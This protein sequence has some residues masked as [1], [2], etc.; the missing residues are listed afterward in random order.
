MARFWI[1]T[2]YGP[3]NADSAQL[4]AIRVSEI[5]A[6]VTLDKASRS[7]SFAHALA[8]RGKKTGMAIAH[9]IMHP[10]DSI[11]GIP[12]GVARYFKR[13]LDM[14]SGRAQSASDRSSRILENK[15]DPY[16]APDGPM[17]AGR[18]GPNERI[19]PPDQPYASADPQ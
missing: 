4:L 15:G 12:M 3:L 16:R 14:W 9:V 10:I 19:D 2:P 7:G 8:A 5:P 13:Q 1:Q 11:T 6:M 17:V 18:S